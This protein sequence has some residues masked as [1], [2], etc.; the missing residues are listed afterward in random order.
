MSSEANQ[1]TGNSR[2]YVENVP[3]I[4]PKNL[5]EDERLNLQHSILRYA[6]KG[7]YGVALSESITDILDVGSG[8]GIWGQ[9]VAQQFPAASVFG[10]DLEPA[11]TTPSSLPPNY[12]FVQGNVLQGL[13]FP[14]NTFD[15]THQRMLIG[16]IPQRDWPYVIQELE[17]VTRPGGLIELLECAPTISPLGSAT[18]FI[19]GWMKDLCSSR[20]IDLSKAEELGIMLIQA[21]LRQVAQ[22]SIDIF[23]GAWDTQIGALLEKNFLAGYEALKP[24]IC[25]LGKVAPVEFDRQIAS[26]VL[27]WKEQPTFQRFY[28][29]YGQVV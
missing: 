21:G 8:T 6:L 12:Y 18:E 24:A 14:N 19:Y 28:L 13:P 15:F 4:L 5:G 23:L 2:Y 1:E 22:Q 16:A 27:E 20:G 26:A 10:V 29:A 11:H 9:E 7:N 25:N 3:Y 17:R